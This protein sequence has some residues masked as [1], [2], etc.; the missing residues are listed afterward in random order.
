[1]KT[2]NEVITKSEQL[3]YNGTITVPVVN[4]VLRIDKTVLN[5]TELK[6]YKNIDAISKGERSY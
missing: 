2:L 6:E 1:M 4:G 3:I 5:I